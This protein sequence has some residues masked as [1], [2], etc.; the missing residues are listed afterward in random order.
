MS[1]YNDREKQIVSVCK[2][3]KRIEAQDVIHIFD[4]CKD[5]K[6]VASIYLA[7]LCKSGKLRRVIKGLYSLPMP[8]KA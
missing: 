6:R 1:L 7:D 5:P 2:V 8:K 4:D 3:K